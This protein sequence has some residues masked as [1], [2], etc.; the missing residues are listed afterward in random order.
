MKKQD[1]PLFKVFVKI[2]TLL[3]TRLL[4]YNVQLKNIFNQ[5]LSIDKFLFNNP[6]LDKHIKTQL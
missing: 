4:F 1:Y 5:Y 3:E 6:E 2:S